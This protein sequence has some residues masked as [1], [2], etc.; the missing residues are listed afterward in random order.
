MSVQ[1][2]DRW[3]KDLIDDEVSEAMDLWINKICPYYKA[4]ARL[5]YV[6][7]GLAKSISPTSQITC[8]VLKTVLAWGQAG[9]DTYGTST[10]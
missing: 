9:T 5:P 10:G 7:C 2:Q 3:A 8:I 4:P 1:R 6:Q